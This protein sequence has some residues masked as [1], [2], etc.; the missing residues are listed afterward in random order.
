MNFYII[1]PAHNE[2]QY[3]GK[4]LDS[5]VNQT[6][7]P[8]RVV[9]VNDNSTDRTYNIC[10]NYAS[11]H[12]FI[13][14]I[15]TTSSNKHLPG[16]KI[17]KAFNKGL[18]TLD[19]NYNIIC[20]F[21]AD[22]IFPVNYLE[23]ISNHFKTKPKLGMASGFCYIEKDNAWL[24]ENL[25]NKEHIRGA[26]KAY[27]KECFNQIGQLKP[28]MGWDTVDELLAKYHGWEILTDESL[29]VKHLKP[30]GQ[31]YNKASKYLQ[32]EA[33]YKMRYGFWITLIS[34]LKLA[35][36]KKSFQLFKDYMTG[37]FKAQSNKVDYLVSKAEG[38]FI[39]DL[40]WK[41]IK[42]KFS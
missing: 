27:R 3:I 40:R 14:V 31:S 35:Y 9:I 8:K 23:T 41:G 6:L 32:G 17:I 28:S 16:S 15:N 2:D 20:K 4:T 26:L 33:M 21:D 18:S 37:Y 39:R 25:T 13:S 42:S 30:T 1:I 7:L 19:D 38:K 11:K 36:K 22:L 12:N 29:H 10:S 5:L 34:A 24:L